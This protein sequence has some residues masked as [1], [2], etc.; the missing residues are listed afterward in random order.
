[1]TTSHHDIVAGE[2]LYS[3]KKNWPFVMF[4][5][6]QKKNFFAKAYKVDGQWMLISDPNYEGGG[7]IV[8]VNNY[9]A[10]DQHDKSYLEVTKILPNV[11]I[12]EMKEV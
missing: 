1:M 8:I 7:L 4:P 6:H 5:N 9:P 12:S 2:K 10:T 3:D 11:L